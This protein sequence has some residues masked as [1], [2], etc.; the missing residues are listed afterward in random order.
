MFNVNARIKKSA[1]DDNI[2]LNDVAHSDPIQIIYPL[3]DSIIYF[4]YF[5]Y[6]LFVFCS[7][8]PGFMSGPALTRKSG[9]LLAQGVSGLRLYQKYAVGHEEVR[10]DACPK[11]AGCPLIVARLW[12]V[13]SDWWI[14]P[15]GGILCYLVLFPFLISADCGFYDEPTLRNPSRRPPGPAGIPLRPSPGYGRHLIRLSV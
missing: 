11:P 10:W 9:A 15:Y 1:M 5:W 4:L 13:N 3:K 8:A 14:L 6:R 7:A 12:A 2:G